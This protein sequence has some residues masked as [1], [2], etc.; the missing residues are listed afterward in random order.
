M[1]LDTCI[2]LTNGGF[3]VLLNC[4]MFETIRIC[5]FA[6]LMLV[7]KQARQLYVYESYLSI[8]TSSNHNIRECQISYNCFPSLVFPQSVFTSL[9]ET[10]STGRCRAF[11]LSCSSCRI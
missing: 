2:A 7:L 4:H 6:N 8:K 3:K 1:Q 11:H 5:S 9:S 10:S